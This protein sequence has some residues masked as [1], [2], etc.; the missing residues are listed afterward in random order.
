VNLPQA[1]DLVV[2]YDRLGLVFG[3]QS[4]PLGL[5][6]G[7]RPGPSEGADVEVAYAVHVR[8]GALLY[9]R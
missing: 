9:A 1:Y 2:A 5:V 6:F 8:V 4:G 3:G 7:G